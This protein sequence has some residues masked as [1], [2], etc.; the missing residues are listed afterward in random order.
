MTYNNDDDDDEDGNDDDDDTF[1][2]RFTISFIPSKAHTHN[3]LYKQL[4]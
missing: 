4:A 3:N 2:Q 1:I